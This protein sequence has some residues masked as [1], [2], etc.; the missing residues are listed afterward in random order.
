MERGVG[1]LILETS[2]WALLFQPFRM[3][4]HGPEVSAIVASE[5]S[6][7]SLAL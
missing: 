1:D 6:G 3:L 2:E 5:P 7:T 4:K